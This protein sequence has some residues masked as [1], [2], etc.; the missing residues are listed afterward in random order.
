[1][2]PLE[3]SMTKETEECSVEQASDKTEIDGHLEFS[4]NGS[5]Y[6]NDGDVEEVVDVEEIIDK[7]VLPPK[8]KLFEE[9]KK[10]GVLEDYVEVVGRFFTEKPQG[11]SCCCCCC[12][13]IW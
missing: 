9:L 11:T 7:P 6:G 2:K 10:V 1:V 3:V 12:Y 13:N 8:E 4:S 5:Y